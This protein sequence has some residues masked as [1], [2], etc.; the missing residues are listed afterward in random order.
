SNRGN[1][2]HDQHEL[3]LQE[4]VQVVVEKLELLSVYR[5]A[6]IQATVWRFWQ[7]RSRGIDSPQESQSLNHEPGAITDLKRSPQLPPS[8]LLQFPRQD[9]TTERFN[10][11]GHNGFQSL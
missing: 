7:N 3:V 2:R 4:K 11:P 1:D 8:S 9:G 10:R 5:A 6:K